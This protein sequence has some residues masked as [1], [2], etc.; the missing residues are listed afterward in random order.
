MR[1]RQEPSNLGLW[2]TEWAH[3]PKKGRRLIFLVTLR[4]IRVVRGVI[5]QNPPRLGAAGADGRATMGPAG[6]DT[7]AQ[8]CFFCQQ[9]GAQ[10]EE[11]G[12]LSVKKC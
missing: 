7:T 4:D 1:F 8:E 11:K 3:P 2:P 10:Y 5:S 6:T 12:E 9:N